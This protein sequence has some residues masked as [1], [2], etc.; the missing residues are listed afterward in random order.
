[1][2]PTWNEMKNN[3]KR[4]RRQ[5]R[6]DRVV[7]RKLRTFRRN[8]R[9]VPTEE[10]ERDLHT[11]LESQLS[12]E[13]TP[14]QQ[15][16]AWKI[17]SILDEDKKGLDTIEN[18]TLKRTLAKYRSNVSKIAWGDRADDAREIHKALSGQWNNATWLEGKAR[19]GLVWTEEELSKFYEVMAPYRQYECFFKKMNTDS[20]MDAETE[21]EIPHIVTEQRFAESVNDLLDLTNDF[22]GQQYVTCPEVAEPDSGAEIQVTEPDSEVEIPPLQGLC[23]AIADSEYSDMIPTF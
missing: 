10:R 20:W 4:E 3:C 21:C 9:V 7:R 18:D 13:T 8:R 1:M 2:A 19:G 22:Y 23:D 16:E 6:A 5:I 15:C 12:E 17:L 11:F 14:L